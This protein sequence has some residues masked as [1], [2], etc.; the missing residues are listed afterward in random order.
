M[1]NSRRDVEKQSIKENNSHDNDDDHV[2]EIGNLPTEE[3]CAN[4]SEVLNCLLKN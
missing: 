2:D 4:Y 1:R 3:K